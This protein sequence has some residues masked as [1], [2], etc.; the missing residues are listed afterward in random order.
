MNAARYLHA[1]VWDNVPRLDTFAARYLHPRRPSYTPIMRRWFKDAVRRAYTPGYYISA[2]LAIVGPQGIGKTML[3]RTLFGTLHGTSDLTTR[4]GA[5]AATELWCVET[6]DT[7]STVLKTLSSLLSSGSHSYYLSRRGKLFR[8][9]P[10]PFVCVVTTNEAAMLR[11]SRRFV[12]VEMRERTDFEALA[13]ERD[14][15]WAE[16]V[17]LCLEENARDLTQHG[18]TQVL[19]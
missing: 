5:L 1:L 9:I 10:R 18:G 15:L 19:P 17:Q 6:Q 12:S 11:A 16:A 8:T 4:D 7:P 3:L 14:Q 2:P 13:A